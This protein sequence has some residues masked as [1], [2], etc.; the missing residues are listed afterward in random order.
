[1]SAVG[2]REAAERKT[3]SL[4]KYEAEAIAHIADGDSPHLDLFSP[5][6]PLIA[7]AEM[8][9]ALVDKINGFADGHIRERE[10]TEFLLPH[11]LIGDGGEASLARQTERLIGRYVR[12]MEGAGAARIRIDRFWIVSQYAGTPSPVHFHSGD[13]SGVMYLKV[14]DIDGEERE[15]QKT[16]ISGRQAGYIN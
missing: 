7:K 3:R 8:P 13:I 6:G 9:R 10:S 14:P 15:E 5:F 2:E 11:E 4:R 16:Y 12:A 1:M